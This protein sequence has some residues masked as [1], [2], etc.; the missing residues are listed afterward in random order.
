LEINVETGFRIWDLEDEAAPVAAS[1]PE[2]V[3]VSATA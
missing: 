2:S 1:V 3:S